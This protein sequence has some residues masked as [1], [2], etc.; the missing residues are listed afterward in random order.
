MAKNT[1]TVPAS[2]PQELAE[3]L[4]KYMEKASL[5]NRSSIMAQA[6]SEFLQ[7]KGC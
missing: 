6:L 1:V 2:I 3:R 4:E 7:K 5:V